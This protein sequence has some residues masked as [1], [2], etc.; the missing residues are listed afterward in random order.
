G[1]DWVVKLESGDFL[2]RAA[3]VEQ[4]ERGV[5]R[6]LVGFHVEDRGIAREGAVV[7]AGDRQ[8]GVVTSGTYS[9]TF[10][11]ALGLASIEREAAQIGAAVDIEVRG[12]RLA[13][14]QV[15]IPFYRRPR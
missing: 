3:L 9:P 13:A 1:L 15:A 6:A 10:E 2:G 4:R 8:V 7:L 14:R 5:P 12:R 11:R